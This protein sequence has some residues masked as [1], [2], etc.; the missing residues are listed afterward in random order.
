[1]DSIKNRRSI[2]KYSDK[3]IEASLLNEI[4]AEA[5]QTPTMGNMQLYSGLH[6]C[7]SQLALQS[8]R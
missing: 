5:M 2:R 7:L 4:I 3:D 8:S 6:S 1:M